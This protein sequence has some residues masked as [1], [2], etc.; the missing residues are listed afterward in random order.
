MRTTSLRE[1]T[2][3]RSLWQVTVVGRAG[4]P[5]PKSLRTRHERELAVR[6]NRRAIGSTPTGSPAAR[7]RCSQQTGTTVRVC[8]MR[9]CF[10]TAASG[11]KVVYSGNVAQVEVNGLK[12]LWIKGPHELVDVTRDGYPA[13]ASAR[14]T[15]G[16]ILIWST[17]QV[18]AASGRQL[19]RDS[20]ARHRQLGALTP[21]WPEWNPPPGGGVVAVGH[22]GGAPPC[23]AG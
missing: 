3:D 12:G 9:A 10:L 1:L 18:R 22:H 14:L 15:T 5:E 16:D 19:R 4:K 7:S 23:R 20:C 21:R 2:V 8:Y 17:R 6:A 13:R 11:R